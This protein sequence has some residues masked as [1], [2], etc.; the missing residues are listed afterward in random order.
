MVDGTGFENRKPK[1]LELGGFYYQNA[2]EKWGEQKKLET[3]KLDTLAGA[4]ICVACT[5]PMIQ[6]VRT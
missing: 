5:V 2:R 4:C 3:K 1:S 6:E